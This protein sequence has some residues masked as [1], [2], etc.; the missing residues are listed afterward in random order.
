MGKKSKKEIQQ[1]ISERRVRITKERDE[2]N[3]IRKHRAKFVV[4]AAPRFNHPATSSTTRSIACPSTLDL[5]ENYGLTIDL[6][7]TIRKWVH[8][9]KRTPIHIEFEE[10]DKIS[11]AASL[12]LSAEMHRW[13]IF[14]PNSKIRASTV[15]DWNNEVKWLFCKMGLFKILNLDDPASIPSEDDIPDSLSR[16]YLPFFHGQKRDPKRIIDLRD[17]IEDLTGRLKRRRAFNDGLTEAIINVRQ[18]AYNSEKRVDRWWI[19]ASIDHQNRSLTVMCLDHGIG[20]PNSLRQS[21]VLEL[22]LSTFGKLK[23]RMQVDHDIIRAAV[24]GG[25]SSTGMSFR[26]K[27]LRKDVK[28]YVEQHDSEGALRIFSGNGYY[29]YKMERAGASSSRSRALPK[30]FPGTF[31]EWTIND[32]LETEK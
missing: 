5:R 23:S 15:S 16:V 20:I 14:R 13:S 30:T 24:E 8:T 11:P 2:I 7:R 27:G 18:H 29:E 4:R 3:R 28:R 10:I 17:S 19:S 1:R 12:I 25:K 22:G 31:I 26:G 9:A 21:K 6:I 32:F